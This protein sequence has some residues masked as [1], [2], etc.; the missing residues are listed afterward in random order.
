MRWLIIEDDIT[1]DRHV[2][3]DNAPEHSLSVECSCGA[4]RDSEDNGV[5]IHEQIQ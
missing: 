1:G 3:P 5:I 4:H 2:V